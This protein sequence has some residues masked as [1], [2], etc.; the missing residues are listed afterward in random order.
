MTKAFM[1]EA[2][3][4]YLFTRNT[5]ERRYFL[6]PTKHNREA[7]LYCVADAQAKFPVQIH[8]LV[9]MSNHVH[10]VLTDT[11]G[12]APLFA[13]AMD[14]HLARLVNCS[15]GRFGS[16]WEGSLRPNWCVLPEVG[17]ILSKVVYTLTNPVR[18][19]LVERHH[20][21]PGAITTVAQVARGRIVTK[22]PTWYFARTKDPRLLEREL[23]IS[24]V[25]GAAVM[26]GEDYGRML[27]ERVA[28]EERRIAEERAAEGRNWLGRKGCYDIDPFASPDKKWKPF[29]RS[30]RVAASCSEARDAWYLRLG[31]FSGQY[32]DARDDFRRGNRDA[33]F[34]CGTFAMRYY[35][36]V[37]IEPLKL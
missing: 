24:P 3:A 18:A 5:S 9:V 34:P 13:Q 26:S 4:T 6:R 25:P 16:M 1:Y 23:T 37:T 10:V 21:W 35:W 15:M 33:A 30:P 14:Q 20:L 7:F 36:D 2:G 11:H 19:G 17:D 8:A 29:E 22:R 27:D 32:Q 12:H 31:I 28:A